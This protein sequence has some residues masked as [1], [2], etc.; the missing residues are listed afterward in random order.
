MWGISLKKP[1]LHPRKILNTLL[2]VLITG[3]RW[4]DVPVGAQWASRACAHKY[5][6]QW[7]ENGLLQLVLTA[8]QEK[9]IEWKLIDLTRLAVDGFFSAGKGGGEKVNHGFKGNFGG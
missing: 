2:W 9:C 5:L 1:P 6:G 3:A 7:K 4:C 8:L